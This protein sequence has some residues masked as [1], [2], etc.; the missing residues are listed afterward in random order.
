MSGTGMYTY[1][2]EEDR[3]EDPRRHD[4]PMPE[5]PV[6]EGMTWP[7]DTIAAQRASVESADTVEVTTT[8]MVTDPAGHLRELLAIGLHPGDAVVEV[9]ES[10]GAPACEVVESLVK[11]DDFV[12]DDYEAANDF[13][14]AVITA[15]AIVT[16]E[17]VDEARRQRE[18]R[19]LSPQRQVAEPDGAAAK[20]VGVKVPKTCIMRIS[21]EVEGEAQPVVDALWE[22][23]QP[24]R[25][26]T[27]V[28]THADADGSKLRVQAEYTV[29]GANS[30]DGA[31][32]V[33]AA[34]E[35]VGTAV[36]AVD[37]WAISDPSAPWASRS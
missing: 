17:R 35:A 15:C 30:N 2:A 11:D 13:T 14:K 4:G 36:V 28:V 25:K 23:W 7:S 19:A 18:D 20:M 24:G 33:R 21:A 37:N 9:L 31:K 1:T 3:R 8:V 10:A 29:K 34:A 6:V 22:K 12:L 32:K 27:F 16:C 26:G 5:R